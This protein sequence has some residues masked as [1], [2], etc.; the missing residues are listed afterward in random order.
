[1]G[2][3]GYQRAFIRVLRALL[4]NPPQE[5][6]HLL[7][8]RKQLNAETQRRRERIELLRKVICAVERSCWNELRL[9]RG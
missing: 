9:S 3:D 1:M 7:L 5:Y 4:E 8:R 6:L 2:R